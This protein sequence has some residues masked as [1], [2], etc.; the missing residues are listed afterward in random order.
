[1]CRRFLS[2]LQGSDHTRIVSLSPQLAL[3]AT[4]FRPLRGLTSITHCRKC[5]DPIETLYRVSDWYES[6]FLSS[7]LPMTCQYFFQHPV[8]KLLMRQCSAADKQ[9]TERFTGS[10]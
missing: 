5:F 2:P 8:K 6:C 7:L 4:T 1:M 3:W 9:R 10:V